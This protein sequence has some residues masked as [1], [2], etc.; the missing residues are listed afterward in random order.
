MKTIRLGRLLQLLLLGFLTTTPSKAGQPKSPELGSRPKTDLYGDLLPAG[1]VAR[2]GTAQFHHTG[3]TELSFSSDGKFVVTGASDRSVRIWDL[4]AGKLR[5]TVRLQGKIGNATGTALSF[6]GKLFASHDRNTLVVWDVDTGKVL[7]QLP[8]PTWA[9][10]SSA[11]IFT[12]DGNAL[13]GWNRRL[14]Q[15]KI[16][17]WKRG[18]ESTIAVPPSNQPSRDSSTHVCA[19]PDGKFVAIGPSWN[20]PLG[21]WDVSNGKRVCAID[22]RASISCFAPD[23]KLLAVASMNQGAGGLS[24]LRLYEVPSGKELR[25]IPLTSQGFHWWLAFSPDGNMIAA[26]D[27]QGTSLLDSRTGKELHRIDESGAGRQRYAYFSPDGRILASYLLSRI[28]LWDT[29][30]G[31]ELHERAGITDQVCGAAYS[32]DGRLLATGGWVDRTI[33]LWDSST[34]RRVRLLEPRWHGAQDAYVRYFKFSADTRMLVVGR[35][36]GELVFIDTVSGQARR[37]LIFPDAIPMKRQFPNFHYFHWTPD[38]RRAVTAERIVFPQ[39]SFEV[40]IWDTSTV[41]LVASQIVPAIPR[42]G[43]TELGDQAAFLTPDGVM[44]ADAVTAQFRLL[45]PGAWAGPLIASPNGKLFAAYPRQKD[46]SSLESITIWEATTGKKVAD[47]PVG[48]VE[49]LA[50]A[51]DNRTLVTAEAKALRVWDLTTGKERHSIPLPDDY[52]ASGE[53]ANGLYLSPDGLRATTVLEDCTLLVWALPPRTK[54]AAKTL[55]DA[56]EGQTWNDLAAEDAARA[57]A[58]IWRLT[59]TPTAAVAVLGKNLKPIIPPNPER[60]DKYVRELDNEAFTAREAAS[61][62]LE[63]MGPLVAPALSEAL[64]AN[65]SAESRR[66]IEDVLRNLYKNPCSQETVQR[67]RAIQVLAEI[68]SPESRRVLQ[69]MAGGA[70]GAPETRES[71]AAL[72]VARQHALPR[73]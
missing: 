44:V 72:A 32:G 67:L 47:L 46:Q 35:L 1:A 18:K 39:D 59:D 69:V 70:P 61:R 25:Q 27:T 60:V 64:K 51:S 17:E 33:P 29:A 63:A 43:W 48:R 65:P 73:N 42:R 56:E 41:R 23:G 16:W 6:D 57:Y 71:K 52:L 15:V 24:V 45:V 58:A 37:S 68:S 50:L 19:S 38:Q 3:L 36:P 10:E 2:V 20:E 22:A 34:G 5:R 30:T 55:S 21:I 28:H 53:T 40:C 9:E 12:V 26:L 49:H 66:R 7:K 14:D 62:A 8:A 13:V 11:L 31:K 54:P 4:A